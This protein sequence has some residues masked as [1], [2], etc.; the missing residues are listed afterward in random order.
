MF[1]IIAL[2]IALVALLL[3]LILTIREAILYYQAHFSSGA[4]AGRIRGA[5]EPITA[6]AGEPGFVDL[7]SLRY[8]VEWIIKDGDYIL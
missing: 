1:Q 4:N 8:S 5:S 2:S 3:D 7:N 6:P